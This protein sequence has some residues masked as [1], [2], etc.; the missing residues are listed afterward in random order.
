VEGGLKWRMRVIGTGKADNPGFSFLDP[1]IAASNGL[2]RDIKAIGAFL[3]LNI[4]ELL[5]PVP[6]FFD[7]FI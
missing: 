6:S 4:C 1:L 7:Y 5:L 3:S 2:I